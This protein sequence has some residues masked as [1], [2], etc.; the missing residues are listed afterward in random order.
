MET[1]NTGNTNTLITIS[2]IKDDNR[3]MKTLFLR[4]L[5]FQMLVTFITALNTIVDSFIVSGFLGAQALSAIAIYAPVMRFGLL[6]NVV[7]VGAQAVIGNTIGRG[8][9][10]KTTEIFSGSVSILFCVSLIASVIIAAFSNRISFLLCKDVHLV[11]DASMYIKGMMIG[12]P[13]EMVSRLLVSLL[14]YSSTNK[15]SYAPLLTMTVTNTILDFVAVYVFPDN[16][17][18]IGLA[19]SIGSII[20][21]L[22]LLQNYIKTSEGQLI[23]F[24]LKSISFDG[25]SNVLKMGSERIFFALG[26]IIATLLINWS[27]VNNLGSNYLSIL[28]LRNTSLSFQQTISVG[29]SLTVFTL[30]N[31]YEGQKNRNMCRKVLVFAN[32]VGLLLSVFYLILNFLLTDIIGNAVFPDDA[33]LRKS[34]TFML[35]AV[36]ISVFPNYYLFNVL[37][38]WHGQGEK[39]IVNFVTLMEKI[40]VAF[41]ALILP[42]ISSKNL[43]WLNILLGDAVCIIFLLV[44]CTIRQKR[45]IPDLKECPEVSGKKDTT[46]ILS[47][48]IC[49][50][51]DAVKVSETVCNYGKQKNVISRKYNLLGLC[52]EEIAASAF[53]RA[54]TDGD[55][56]IDIFVYKENEDFVASVC[57]D[58]E[59]FNPVETSTEF[60]A[61]PEANIKN[62]GLK[63]VR[64][65]A[66]EMN[67]QKVNGLNYLVIR[68]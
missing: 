44:Y 12:F 55:D 46:D 3:I 29:L 28:T 60:D 56:R 35:I 16:L 6:F 1:Y 40:V 36:A 19:S 5:P 18:L 4:I 54:K 2:S 53:S 27:I 65:I 52:L 66:K 67:Y 9:S 57:D 22:M 31:F 50:V 34:A 38:S 32:R 25:F 26:G 41:M 15:K 47:I 14:S 61:D 48:S 64:K 8:D 49:S 17:F 68:I 24:C 10:K 23:R 58:C 21:A 59:L 51:E 11:Y 33:M 13:A 43:I 20:Y 30:T 42:W 63:I 7:V 45:I 62:I 37:N 39:K